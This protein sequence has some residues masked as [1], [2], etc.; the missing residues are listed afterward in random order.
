MDIISHR[1]EVIEEK[2]RKMEMALMLIGLTAERYAKY[3]CPVDTGRLR[4]SI[5]HGVA[6]GE[7]A[8]YVGTNV[9]YAPYVEVGTHKQKPQPYLRPA[10][11]DH[12]DEY[13]AIAQRVLQE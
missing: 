6:T 13:S 3:L 12:L 2:N 8:V 5:T 10:V 7:E 1:K 9:E 11:A 4:N